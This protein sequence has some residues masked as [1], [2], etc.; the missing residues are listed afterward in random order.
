[1]TLTRVHTRMISG[2]RISVTDFGA[3]G[4][5]VTDDTGPFQAAINY[6]QAQGITLR[7]PVAPNA[8]RL[9][10]PLGITRAFTIE[11]DGVEPYTGGGPQGTYL[12]GKG[13][14]LWFDHPGIGINIVY[15]TSVTDGSS[16][17][18]GMRIQSIGTTRA[19]PL[20]TANWVPN[21]FH[22][23]FVTAYSGETVFDDIMILGSFNGIYA[24]GRVTCNRVRGQT[25]GTFIFS[26]FS[27][28]TA[29]FN[30][31]HF[32]PFWS[33]N[34]NIMLYMLN[35]SICFRF[36]RLDNPSIV[37]CF[38]IWARIGMFI[39]SFNNRSV[40]SL[41]MVNSEFDVGTIGIYIS[42][43]VNAATMFISNHTTYGSVDTE[44]T[45]ALVCDGNNCIIRLNNFKSGLNKIGIMRING[46]GNYIQAVNCE[47]DNWDFTAS[48]NPAFYIGDGNTMI[49][50]NRPYCHNGG[51]APWFGGLGTI[52]CPLGHG[53]GTGTTNGSGDLTVTHN[54]GC[55]PRVVTA[56]PVGAAYIHIQPTTI[57]A[58]TIVFRCM[59]ATGAALASSPVVF[60]YTMAY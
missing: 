8:Y 58:T 25:F 59:N 53:V 22:Y 1:M 11:G 3:V 56:T 4:D 49:M 60:N 5:G 50:A 16:E 17:I 57:T 48:N 28:D 10:H 13:S 32:W 7:I 12:R 21:V 18:T 42:P 47:A 24:N 29:R 2:S 6:C 33:T 40:S 30:D 31:C 45:S 36:S 34:S 39:D 37:G 27:G 35:N 38:A 43:A 52:Q 55:A 19:Q 15:G 51:T 9:T 41:R 14:W 46:T 54:L 44:V 23:D 26:E 20:P